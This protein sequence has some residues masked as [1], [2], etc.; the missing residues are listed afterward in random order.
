MTKHDLNKYAKRIQSRLSTRGC[1][2]TLEQ[3]RQA[4][5]N[6]VGENV[7]SET[8]LICVTGQLTNQAQNQE[9]KSTELATVEAN[10]S[11]IEETIEQSD[12]E[13][14]RPEVSEDLSEHPGIEPLLNPPE[15]AWESE[16]ESARLAKSNPNSL[17]VVTNELVQ[18]KVEETFSNQPVALKEQI[19]DYS[20]QQTF[21]D[22]EELE[23]FL[24]EL[25]ALEFNLLVETLREHCEQRGSMLNLVAKVIDQQQQTDS[26][27]RK[28]FKSDYQNRLAQFQQGI[29][30]RLKSRRLAQK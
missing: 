4:L 23:E 18:Q 3:C 25:R 15:D 7:P 21:Q 30:R 13:I 10:A 28:K 17:E 11:E 22:T 6:Q 1:R 29:E 20:T 16:P 9:E 26:E 2:Y 5:T 12:L 14:P 19:L 8:D 27:A 24:G